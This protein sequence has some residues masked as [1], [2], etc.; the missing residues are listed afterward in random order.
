MQFI[1]LKAQQQRIRENIDTAITKVL[2]SGAYIMGREVFKMEEE[3]SAF[4]GSKHTLSC[5]SGTDALLLPLMAWG[6]GKGD[7]VFVP[8]FT[9][10]A[11]AEVVALLG[12]T[13]IFVDVKMDTFNICI[14]SLKQGV[15][16]AKIAG[17]NPAVLIGVDL[18]GQPADWDTLLPIA[19]ENNM[20]VLDDAAQG[21]GGQY[22]DRKIGTIG[23]ATAT[24]FFPAKPLGC[25]GD[26]GA[27]FTNDDALNET[28][29]SL[30]VHGQDNGD[31]YKNSLVGL[32]ARMD[33]IQCAI[34]SEK[35]KIFAE[36]LTMRD[37]IAKRYCTGLSE[38]VQ[39][40]VQLADTQSAWAQYT[41]LLKEGANRSAIQAK[42]QEVGV[43][44]AVYYPIAMHNQKAYQSGIKAGGKLP[45]S[46]ALC[47]RVLSLPMHPYLS[48]D[49]QDKI[50]KS[51]K[52]VL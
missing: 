32:N 8:S 27:V 49:D 30:R 23:D 34:L 17:L 12:A 25:Y 36:E 37:A 13:P 45:V 15:M 6:V 26:G 24:S 28:M 10:T 52:K 20:K 16:S 29:I 19:K 48:V 3:L 38:V 40:P 41:I 21:F 1:D 44:S 35:L 14:D 47:G 51:L 46:E 39:T 4:C 33:T 5:S 18:F 22:K 9:F 31:K 42:L 7:A 50:I 43:P 2:D 11:T